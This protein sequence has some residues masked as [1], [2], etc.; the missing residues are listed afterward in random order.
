MAAATAYS[1]NIYAV[2]THLFL[3]TDLLTNFAKKL[4]IKTINWKKV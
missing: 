2:K 4:K 1:D 3:G